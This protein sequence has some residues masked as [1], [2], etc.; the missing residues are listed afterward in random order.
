M[1]LL[2][3]LTHHPLLAS[4]SHHHPI[5]GFLLPLFR[6]FTFSRLIKV[7]ELRHGVLQTLPQA[8]PSYGGARCP[9]IVYAADISYSPLRRHRHRY[10]RSSSGFLLHIRHTPSRFNNSFVCSKN[11]F[12]DAPFPATVIDLLALA[13]Q[14]RST[15]SRPP[16]SF[17]HMIKRSTKL[18]A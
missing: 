10:C 18:P 17:T 13:H 1:L 7:H 5:P 12:D 8:K 3:L 4:S 2:L 9:G 14:Q 16:L 11:T 15:P 6:F